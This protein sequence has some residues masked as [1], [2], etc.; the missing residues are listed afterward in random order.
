MP[1]YKVATL[2]EIPENGAHAVRIEG[3][4][5][6][7]FHV[8][9][10]IFAIDDGCPHMR[11]DLS[12]GVVKDETVLCGWHGWQFDLNTG[13]CLNIEWARVRTYPV[14]NRDGSIFVT[15]EP[16]PPPAEDQEEEMPRIV[17]KQPPPD[18]D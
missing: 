15:V 4:Q 18:E 6:G 1:E 2:E 17:W 11:A 10:K 12:C 13:R 5:I 8:G 7:L 9:G 14:E 16:D 3:R